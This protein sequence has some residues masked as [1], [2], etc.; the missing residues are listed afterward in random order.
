M[1]VCFFELIFHVPVNSYVWSCRDVA[2][3]YVTSIC[4]KHVYHYQKELFVF[5]LQMAALL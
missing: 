4:S 5:R 1:L 3:M 2:S